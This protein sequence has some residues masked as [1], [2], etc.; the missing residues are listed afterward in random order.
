MMLLALLL[1]P[2]FALADST[3]ITIPGN[4]GGLTN[5]LAAVPLVQIGAQ[6][7][8]KLPALWG[9]GQTSGAG[10]GWFRFWRSIAALPVVIKSG[11]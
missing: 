5:F 1:S 9:K 6:V 3:T 2:L 10:S 4:L 7:L 8:A 11:P